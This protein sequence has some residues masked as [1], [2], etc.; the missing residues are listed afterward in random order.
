MTK[1][2]GERPRCKICTLLLDLELVVS[3]DFYQSL[4]LFT[5]LL[6]ISTI[7]TFLYFV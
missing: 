2:E 7:P 1:H 6:Y 3:L 4:P 5:V